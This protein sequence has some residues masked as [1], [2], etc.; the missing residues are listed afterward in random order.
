MEM[1]Y[2]CTIGGIYHIYPC[3]HIDCCGPCAGLIYEAILLT[4]PGYNMPAMTRR[5]HFTAVIFR[6]WILQ[7]FCNK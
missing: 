4:V 6:L 5:Q 7:Y 3:Q 1:Q 2:K